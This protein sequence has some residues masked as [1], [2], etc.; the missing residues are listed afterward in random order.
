M[1]QS[2]CGFDPRPEH[3]LSERSTRHRIRTAI[4]IFF[5]L[6]FIGCEKDFVSDDQ[7]VYTLV[8][9]DD[10]PVPASLASVL[11][12]T[13]T[14]RL[15]SLLGT[16]G[17]DTCEYHVQLQSANTISNIE[18]PVNDCNLEEGGSIV[19]RIDVGT[20]VG[21]HDFLFHH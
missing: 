1:G 16:P 11:G 10:K 17:D 18:G 4:V 3:F 19:I 5:S 8:A 9:V 12:T 6:G 7:L 21:L 20:S 14:V 15:G 2:P 13:T